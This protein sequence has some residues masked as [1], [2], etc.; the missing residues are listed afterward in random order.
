MRSVIVNQSDLA[1][2]V[3]RKLSAMPTRKSGTPPIVFTPSMDATL[4][5][6]RR[7]KPPKTWVQLAEAF[8]MCE[9]T[10]RKRYRE[11]TA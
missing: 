10:L 5:K 3:E 4:L 6:A 2:A 11:L 1:A 9:G 8:E 7:M